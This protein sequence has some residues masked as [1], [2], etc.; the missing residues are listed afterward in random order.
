[1]KQKIDEIELT[2]RS[3]RRLIATVKNNPVTCS[4]IEAY[5]RGYVGAL[6]YAIAFLELGRNKDEKDN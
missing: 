3:L 5:N 1:M 6:E 2:I 4:E